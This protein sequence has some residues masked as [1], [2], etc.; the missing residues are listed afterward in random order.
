MNRIKI[1]T[2]IISDVHLGSKV[3]RSD[4]LVTELKKYDYKHLILLGDIFD[5]L[6]FK[7]L[8]KS[9][10]DLLSYIRK[11][12]KTVNVVWVIGNHDILLKDIAGHLLGIDVV[13][14]FYWENNGKSFLALHGHQFD[15]FMANNIIISNVASFIYDMIQKID[16][17]QKFSRWIKQ[18]S[19][20]WLRLSDQ[21][22]DKAIHYAEKKN[23]DYIFCG[24]THMPMNKE[25]YYNTGCWT[26]IPSSYI[27]ITDSNEIKINYTN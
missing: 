17:K 13:E 15:S 9:H 16:K 10:W 3:S 12:S 21:I 4:I 19:K 1:D 20:T 5:D 14:E 26:D 23:S 22:A 7:R 2:I 24:H 6:N 11:Q 27:T 18:I 8:K 25:N